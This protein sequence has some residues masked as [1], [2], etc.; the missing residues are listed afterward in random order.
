MRKLAVYIMKR[1]G[2]KFKYFLYRFF[3]LDFVIKAHRPAKMAFIPKYESPPFIKQLIIIMMGS[4]NAWLIYPIGYS[5]SH[6]G[7]TAALNR[8]PQIHPHNK[9]P[10]IRNRILWKGVRFLGV[11]GNR[12][13]RK[14]LTEVGMES[15]NQIHIQPLASCIGE[16]KVYEH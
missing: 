16:R 15:A 11:G 13:A 6:C 2:K 14:K 4:Y 5:R 8:Q 10:E 9:E 3:T 1:H 7:A 12:S